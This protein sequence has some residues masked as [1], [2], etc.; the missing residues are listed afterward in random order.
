MK[1]ME[2][3]HFSALC[4]NHCQ[5]WFVIGASWYILNLPHDQQSLHHLAKHHV[6]SVQKVALCASDEEL[7]SVC[8]WATVGHGEQA[9]GI[10][11]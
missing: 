8:P 6:L 3:L 4:D 2:M 5:F 1:M 10:M 7:A 11:L 9:R